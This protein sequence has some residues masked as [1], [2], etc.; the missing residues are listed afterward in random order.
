[1]VV[2][3][4]LQSTAPG[5]SF[6]VRAGTL[7]LSGGRIRAIGTSGFAGGNLTLQVTGALVLS[8]S[9]PT[10]DVSGATNG[11]LLDVT[12]GSIDVRA[13][14]VAADGTGSGACGGAIFLRATGGPL[15]LSAPVR[16][17]GQLF[18]AGG[19]MNLSGDSVTVA[20]TLNASGG[21]FPSGIQL[22]ANTGNVTVTSAGALKANG[23]QIELGDGGDGGPVAILAESGAVS[24]QGSITVTGATPEGAA[25][26]VVIVAGGNVDIAATISA[27]GNG[28]GSDGGTVEIDAGG[29]VT[30][31]GHV[32]AG[33]GSEA[34]GGE[35]DVRADGE[36]A[37]ASGKL[38]QA[39]GGSFG[40]GAI[41][42]RDAS[43]ID[44]AGTL[45]ARGAVGNG[46]FVTL[47]TCRATVSGTLDSGAGGG[48]A[49]GANTITAG[50]VEVTSSGRL[51]ATPCGSGACNAVTLTAGAPA[52]DPLAV[53]SP[54]PSVSIDPQLAACCGN[55]TIEP[56]ETCDDGGGSG[57]DGCSHL[58]QVETTPPCPSDGNECTRDC[59]PSAGCTYQPRTGQA[60]SD[61]GNSCTSDVCAPGA[62][63]IH[64]PRVC[65][66][67]VACTVDSCVNGVGCVATPDD[68]RCDDTESCTSDT[69]VATG[70]VH[71]TAPDGAPCS[72]GSA[73]TTEDACA[74]GV[75][76]PQGPPLHCDDQ[77]SC[78][79]DSCAAAI[80]CLYDEQPGLCPCSSATGPEPAGTACADGDDCSQDDRCDGSGACVAGPSCPDD[81]NACTTE[82]CIHLGATDLCLA[83]DTACVVDCGATP[84]GTPC[85][86]GSACT[87][88]ECQGGTC[89]ATPVPCGDGDRCTGADYCLAP[90]GCRSG[91]PPL[92]EPTCTPAE[93]LDAFVC[94][95]AKTDRTGPPFA[96]V[97]GLPVEDRFGSATAD[98]R[99]RAGLC[100]PANVAGNDPGAPAHPDKLGGYL[101]R[102]RDVVASGASRTALPVQSAFGT[103]RLD[104]K[105]I[106]GALEPA[107]FDATTPP[108]PPVPPDPD[109]FTC[110]KATI[111]PGDAKFA[112][113]FA[114]PVEDALGPLTIDVV[115]PTRLCS[116]VDVN[117]S[118]PTAP[119]HPLQLLCF[120]VRSSSGTPRFVKR[121]GV[122]IGT[123]L[124]TGRLDATSLKE[125]CVPATLPP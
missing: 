116:P 59:S 56:G 97:F 113:V 70:C 7:T 86:D 37:I 118:D 80:G 39:S 85:S 69:C 79:A 68:A 36:I 111:T 13:G 11:G 100:L 26:E 114:L 75:C 120:R 41:T 121:R 3:G 91:A 99:K 31:A 89:A 96:P 115:R 124:G 95:G 48:G 110:Y 12:A 123:E 23:E 32:R 1:M 53:A 5:G 16:A 14:S 104:L 18:C 45:D 107:A 61:D 64:P 54:A 2:S 102:L 52:I 17:T 94:Y 9:G 58:C 109:H 28:G 77:N 66:D 35:I 72:D 20:T 55:A 60:C 125:L 84:D 44:V 101:V 34:G 42:L 49:S 88:G 92:D 73:C 106:E 112:P 63:C 57:C 78:T 93:G 82:T 29:N 38:V 40:G 22:T 4:T 25:G 83:L 19:F 15:L 81:G 24:L 71:A 33:G 51:L 122:W 119:L 47:E 6:T 21:D 8:G 30:I 10:L 117:G 76:T 98:V 90:I 105:K 74:G 87:T 50:V 108:G 67:G 65:N 62:A 46:G 103:Q 43:R 27:E